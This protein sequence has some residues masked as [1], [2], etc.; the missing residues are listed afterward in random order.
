VPKSLKHTRSSGSDQE[1]E[2]EEEAGDEGSLSWVVEG[3]LLESRRDHVLVAMDRK[4]CM[5]VGM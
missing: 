2:E 1:E 4:V 3:A 5:W